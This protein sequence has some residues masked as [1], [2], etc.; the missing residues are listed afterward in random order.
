MS[1]WKKPA[2]RMDYLFWLGF[3]P[4]FVTFIV[5]LLVH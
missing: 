4:P 2:T 5:M 1:W 3:V